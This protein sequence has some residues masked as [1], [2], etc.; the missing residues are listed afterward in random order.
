MSPRGERAPSAA[1][2]TVLLAEDDP[3]LLRVAEVTLR[4]GGY[5]VLAAADGPEA[6]TLAEKHPQIDLLFTDVMLPHGMNGRELADELARRRPGLPVVFASGYSEDI[7]QHR[8][9][10]VAG[11]RL[12]TKP[13]RFEQVADALRSALEDAARHGW[14]GAEEPG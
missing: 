9:A 10:I 4:L 13:Y 1:R 2:R 7:V 14:Q 12:V 3:D 5:R 8:G 11:L 6:L